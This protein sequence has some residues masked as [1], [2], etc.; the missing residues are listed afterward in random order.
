MKHDAVT[1][2]CMVVELLSLDLYLLNK[3]TY[4]NFIYCVFIY[5]PKINTFYYRNLSFNN[6]S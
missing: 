3:L 5:L 1:Y 6:E 2:K 4:Y